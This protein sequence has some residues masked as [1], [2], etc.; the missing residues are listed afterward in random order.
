VVDSQEA[1]D[2]ANETAFGLNASV[3]GR[4][5]RRAH[6]VAAQLRAGTVNINDGHI[7]GFGSADAPMGGMKDSGLGRRNGAEGIL[8]YTEAQN[9]SLQRVPLTTPPRWLPYKV[10]AKGMQMT[11][12][13][14]HKSRIR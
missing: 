8:K 6:K 3:Y 5:L 2:R 11:L 1:V 7:V 4:D 10:Y 14:F 13:L 12:R 9:V